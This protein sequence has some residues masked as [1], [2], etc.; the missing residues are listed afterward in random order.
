MRLRL[1]VLPLALFALAC[2]AP[3]GVV[4]DCERELGLPS[5]VATDILFVIDDSG[6]M[7][8]EQAKVVERLG[9]FVTGLSSG[10]VAHDFHFGVITTSVLENARSCG[11]TSAVLTAFPDAAGRLQL[12]KTTSGLLAADSD[13]K[14]LAY[15]DPDLV[16][17]AALLLGQGTAGSGEE[18][19][20]EAMRLALSAPLIETPLDAVPP[21]NQG[22]L[23]PGARLL[24]V[25]VS[26]EDDCSDPTGAAIA[27]EPSCGVPCTADAECGGPGQYCVPDP[28]VRNGRRCVTN[29][30]ETPAGRAALE[31]IERYVDFLGSLDDGTGRRRSREVF[32]AAIAPVSA[33]AA[34]VP[35]RCRNGADE[36]YGVGVRYR[37]LVDAM[38][39]HAFLASI[40]EDD[41]GAAL[42]G[43]AALVTAPQT[44]EL[45][46]AP[47]DPR[48]LRL[49]VLRADGS[50]VACRLDD[51]FRF[52]PA[53]AGAPARITLE[54]PCR[55]KNGDRVRLQLA[56]AG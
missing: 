20:L 25:I 37:A 14:I 38:G 40:C 51:G 32:V 4:D 49:A 6:S 39:D 12:G 18:M 41:Y 23:R 26:D 16:A 22:F 2:G 46:D 33:D 3:D 42:S 28:E 50:E 5:A 52:E 29:T 56:C 15:D 21:G 53:T 11:A 24:V 45:A 44:L 8:E 27:V 43:I 35:E 13:R 48:L 47:P 36:A 54:G 34:H 55:L 17:Q 10:P 30:C 31:P 9:A 7:A 19:P 1:L